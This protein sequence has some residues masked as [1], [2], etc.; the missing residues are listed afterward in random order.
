[1]VTYSDKDYK[2]T[3]LIKQGKRRMNPDFADFVD[4]IN[5]AFNVSVINIFYDIMDTKDKTPCLSIILEYE[6][7]ELKFRHGYL[8]N[9]DNIKRQVVTKKFKELL[10]QETKEMSFFD[11][12][13]RRLTISKYNLDNLFI[14]F[15]SFEPLAKAEANCLIPESKVTA[16]RRELALNDLWQIYREYSGTTFF[17]YLEEHVNK[18]AKNGVKEKLSKKYFDLL[19]QYDEFG[20]FKEDTFSIMLDSKENFDENYKSNWFYYSRR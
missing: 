4:W 16:L 17:F 10:N 14:I 8:G 1:M 12:L 9:Y 2:E 20:Y 3:K 7:D 15:T 18:Y 11:K 6:R 13:L 19:K 5:K